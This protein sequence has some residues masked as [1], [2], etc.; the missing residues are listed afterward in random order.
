M[1][2]NVFGFWAGGKF[3]PL[4]RVTSIVDEPHTWRVNY[5]DDNGDLCYENFDRLNSIFVTL[6]P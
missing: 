6:L 2:N 4:H 3:I 5:L 1:S